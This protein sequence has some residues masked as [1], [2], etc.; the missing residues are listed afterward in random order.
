[1]KLQPLSWILH[2][3]RQPVHGADPFPAEMTT[4]ELAAKKPTRRHGSYQTGFAGSP[5][6]TLFTSPCK[7]MAACSRNP[8]A[9]PSRASLRPGSLPNVAQFSHHAASIIEKW[10]WLLA[11]FPHWQHSPDRFASAG[12]ALASTLRCAP[13]INRRSGRSSGRRDSRRRSGRPPRRGPS[14]AAG[15]TAPQGRWTSRR[16]SGASTRG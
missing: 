11:T 8:A 16:G 4:R 1:M 10:N 7:R 15:S 14:N 2:A 6:A 3:F 12:I 5:P 9:Y 13:A